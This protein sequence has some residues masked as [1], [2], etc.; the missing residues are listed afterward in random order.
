MSKKQSIFDRSW[1]QKVSR[2]NCSPPP[3]LPGLGPRPRI[4]YQLRVIFGDT[5]A[6]GA[7]WYCNPDVDRF[8]ASLLHIASGGRVSVNADVTGLFVKQSNDTYRVCQVTLRRLGCT[9]QELSELL[10]RTPGACAQHRSSNAAPLL[11]PEPSIDMI[12]QQSGRALPA[13]HLQCPP[14]KEEEEEEEEM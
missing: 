5:F 4:L 13:A 8:I 12:D 1:F 2:T 14:A 10:R 7:Y 6:E 11:V 3:L 9:I